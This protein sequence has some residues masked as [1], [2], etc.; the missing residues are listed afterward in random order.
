MS[1]TFYIIDGF[2][3]IFRAFY[4]IRGGM[5]SP[6]TGEPT[7]AVFGFTG[8]LFKLLTQF[9]PDF[10]AVALDA[11]G[12]TFRDDMYP[13]Y[14]GTR[15]ETPEDLTTQ[16]PR[17]IELI[18]GF[19]I[20]TVSKEGLEADDVIATVVERI[21]N[22]P[23]YDDVHIRII[24]RD[25]D[26]EQLISDRVTLFDIH[27][28]EEVDV[29][30][31]KGSKG[32]RPDQVIDMLA[33]MGDTADNVPGVPG[34]GP[35]TASTLIQMY[36]SI[37]G[38][39]ENIEEIKGKRRE[40]LEAYR[41]GLDLA[42]KLV[43]LKRD[44]DFPFSLAEAETKSP[45][46][47]RLLPL[48]QQLGFRRYQDQIKQ[49]AG[50]QIDATDVASVG[51]GED[52]SSEG[53]GGGGF[54]ADTH[55]EHD[56]DPIEA[57]TYE[58]IKTVAGLN[59][60]VDQLRASPLISVDI[61]TTSLGD[62]ARVC[63]FAFSWKEGHGVYV[64][65][66]S[67]NGDSHLDTKT[68][69][70]QL[71]S[72][73]EDT[74]VKKCGHNLKFDTRILGWEGVTLRGVAFDTMLA[75][76][77][78][79]PGRAGHKL[80]QLVFD[81]LG[82]GM[83]PIS[84][85]IGDGNETSMAEIPL[86]DVA[87]YA[88]E[89]ADMTLR[90]VNVLRPRLE[91]LDLLELLEQVEAPLT[92][93]L[94]RM[95]VMGIVCDPEE[96]ARQGELLSARVDELKEAVFEASGCTFNIDSPRQLADVLFSQLGLP[97][98]K[99][100]KTGYSTDIEVLTNLAADEDKNDPKTLVPGLVIEYR[101]LAKLINTYLGNLR[102]AINPE[103][104]RIH[105]TFH[106]LVTATGRLASQNPNL[107]NIPVRTDVGRQIRKAFVAPE[108]HLLITA[109]YSQIELRVLA[110]LS[111][112]E[113]LLQAF[114]S[115]EDIHNRVASEVYGVGM[116]E[117]G[118]ELRDHA[119]VINFGIIYGITAFGLARRIE[120]LDIGRA[121]ELIAD[122]K[123]RFPGID[124]FLQECIAHATDHGYVKT[125]LGRRRA[126]PEI[127]SSN[128]GRRG[129]GERLAINTV[130]QGSAADLIKLAMVKLEQ[131]ITRE[132]LPLKL[133]LQI[134]DELVLEA[135]KDQAEKM[136]A[137]VKAEMEEALELNVPLVVET[138]LGTDWMSAK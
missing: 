107:Q 89:D 3:Q 93:V 106:Q 90:L 54:S 98:G 74:Q 41:E 68:V 18:E 127:Q 27:K 63:G 76:I 67:P 47:A 5:Q 31:L 84:D 117:V 118:R 114:R 16:I 12:K 55:S 51:K 69:I 77:M 9:D 82:Y 11:P 39:Y 8:M 75:S 48:F 99:K 46:A 53:R 109:D 94:A 133:L 126:I 57:G 132:Q 13:D 91:Q 128:R 116:D 120:G 38:I 121:A 19:G 58:T 52:T 105:T 42:R 125:I 115:G 50:E 7:H 1:R 96:L 20:P 65:T 104:K 43:T 103:T 80:D 137:I 44:G 124:T 70:G 49:L 23:D 62:D 33:L 45:S 25:K 78:I 129:L 10:V 112:D 6:V 135:P 40:N 64:P 71:K 83:K 59:Q 21:V 131:R 2:A 138:G 32:I 95:E 36:G 60:V 87:R 22:D 61:E 134:H 29:E 72:V 4:A 130:V 81:L 17:V 136:A 102:D 26:L 14:K 100:T 119:K 88:A 85:L 122:Y 30:A 123:Q 92:E 34:I 108:G 24:S 15:E 97:P 66:L 56:R 28:E 35:K 79:D 37:D 110:H 86:D 73:L 111:E 101:Q 113:G